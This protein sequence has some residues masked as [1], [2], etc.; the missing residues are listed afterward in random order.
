MSNVLLASRLFNGAGS[1]CRHIRGT[2]SGRIRPLLGAVTALTLTA[3]VSSHVLVGT[4]RPK[5][6]PAEV[7]IYLRAPARYEEV[8]LLNATSRG[9]WAFSAQAQ[10]DKVV[11]N[12]MKEA[13]ALGANGVLLQEVKEDHNGSIG[14]ISAT[15]NRSGGIALGN[16]VDFP[17]HTGTGIAIFVP[18]G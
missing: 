9:G 15:G 7:S 14:V 6:S 4:K 11:D 5:I 17:L 10:T 12:L 3:C 16:T 13:A 18:Q 8:A 2:V 1:V